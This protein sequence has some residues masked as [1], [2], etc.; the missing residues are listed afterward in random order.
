MSALR[1]LVADGNVADIRRQQIAMVGYDAGTGYA[2][3]LRCLRSGIECNTTLS[4]TTWI[5]P[6]SPAVTA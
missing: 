5:S 1:I 3:V 4:T 2:R 6:L